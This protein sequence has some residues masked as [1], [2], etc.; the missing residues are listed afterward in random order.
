MKKILIPTDFSDNSK[1]AIRYAI[2]M[3]RDEPCHIY[4]LHVDVEGL[5]YNE[6]PVY[7]FG[8]NILVE[9]EPKDIHQ[10]L[11]NLEQYVRTISGNTIHQFT[12]GLEEGFFL[13]SIRKYIE[14]KK[15]DLIVMGTKGASDLKEFFM[16]TFSGDVITNLECDVLVVPDQANYKDFKQ[17]VIP[18]DFK[19]VY[20][21]TILKKIAQFIG[22]HKVEIKQ[23]YVTKPGNPLIEN[24]EQ[25]Q[26]LLTKQLFDTIS[27]PVSFHRIIS[28]KPE[29]GI[30]IFAKSVEADLIIMLSKDHDLLQKLFLDTT[31]EEVSFTTQIPLLSLRA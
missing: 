28:R 3:F 8:T 11:K 19:V 9:K 22:S 25:Q 13:E 23:L 20:D 27:N 10:R 31:V 15:I 5:A 7:D 24:V 2:E 1:N 12:T 21:E 26:Q 6:K 16:G 17:V 29:A 18:I 14:K 30:D 4:I